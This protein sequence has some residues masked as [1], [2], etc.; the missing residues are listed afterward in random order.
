MSARIVYRLEIVSEL[1]EVPASQIR[2]YEQLGLVRPSGGVDPASST[3][4][5]SEDDLR[6]LRRIRRIQRDLG[7]SLDAVQVVMRLLDQ[8]EQLQQQIN[9]TDMHR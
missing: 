4:I 9:D 3:R 8:I 1:L 7:L 6:R 5:Y 2:R